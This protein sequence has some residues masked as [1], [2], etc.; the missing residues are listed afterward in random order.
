MLLVEAAAAAVAREDAEPGTP[1]AAVAQVVEDVVVRERRQPAAPVVD[2]D[3]E[4]QELVATSCRETSDSPLGEDD[5]AV[6]PGKVDRPKPAFGDGLSRER[7]L[8]L[9][10]DVGQ[11]EDRPRSRGQYDPGAR[12]GVTSQHGIE[13]GDG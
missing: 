12:R 2:G 1:D 3:G 10:E 11:P 4:V 6:G 5:E 9:R 13:Q 7:V 8:V